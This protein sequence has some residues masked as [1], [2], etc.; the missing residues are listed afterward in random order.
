MTE[1]IRKQNN[2]KQMILA[3]QVF[4][5]LFIFALIA[6]WRYEAGIE[7]KKELVRLACEQ[8]AAEKGF[9]V[10][11]WQ[12]RQ[13]AALNMVIKSAVSEENYLLPEKMREAFIWS[14][15]WQGLFVTDEAG[16]I[17]AATGFYLTEDG[18]KALGELPEIEGIEVAAELAKIPGDKIIIKLP[19][20]EP[21]PGEVYAVLEKGELLALL[22]DPAGVERL[23]IT[24]KNGL[25]L[26]SS[27]EGFP[28]GADFFK[29]DK[30]EILSWGGGFYE[31]RKPEVGSN[32]I[33][34]KDTGGV[35]AWAI[36]VE[37]GLPVSIVPSWAFKACLFL[38]AVSTVLTVFLRRKQK[39]LDK[40]GKEEFTAQQLRER[41]ASILRA[42][43]QGK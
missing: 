1:T 39:Q 37:K 36:A 11:Q 3:A 2:L 21:A 18:E 29:R 32:L 9:I 4:C 5:L 14:N 7:G 15:S 24:D 42:D 38:L 16:I 23:A 25:A 27:P 12:G 20:P 35:F 19:V 26:V 34:R 40:T 30:G 43:R 31:Y 6:L 13:A 22:K 41:M 28:K 17:T 8:Q 33:Y 10:A